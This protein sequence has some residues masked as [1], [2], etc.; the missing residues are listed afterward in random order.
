MTGSE[1]IDGLTEIGVA[2]ESGDKAAIEA[3]FQKLEERVGSVKAI[4][5]FF[6]GLESR[7]PMGAD[8]IV[9]W[10]EAECKRSTI[11]SLRV[12]LTMM[13]EDPQLSLLKRWLEERP[14]EAGTVPMGE[15][16]KEGVAARDSRAVP[17]DLKTLDVASRTL[18]VS[19]SWLQ[20]RITDGLLT[21]HR[22]GGKGPH[23]VSMVEADALARPRRPE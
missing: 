21:T 2:R 5:E 16:E 17:S 6:A 1:L 13:A 15:E 18:G 19:R 22:R 23:L 7:A 12:T 8:G 20:A 9:Y 4:Q 3:A 10:L 14:A 11:Y